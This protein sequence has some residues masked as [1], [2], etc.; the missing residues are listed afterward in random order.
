MG[1]MGIERQS[2]FRSGCVEAASGG[3]EGRWVRTCAGWKAAMSADDL[4]D[5]DKRAALVA[6]RQP[7]VGTDILEA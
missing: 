7:A 6:G 5:G 2:A 4:A 3:V 1:A